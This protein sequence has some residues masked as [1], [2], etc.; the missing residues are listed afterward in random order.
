M[1][2]SIFFFII[3]LIQNKQQNTNYSLIDIEIKTG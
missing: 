2:L 1:K 3:I